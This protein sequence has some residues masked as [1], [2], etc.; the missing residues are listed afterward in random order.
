MQQITL[1]NTLLYREIFR[2]Y[3][4]DEIRKI[5][6]LKEFREKKKMSSYEEL[7]KVIKGHAVRYPVNFLFDED[8]TLKR[9]DKEFYVPNINFT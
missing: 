8:L 1:T 2:C 6:Q 5:D 7:S 9:T 4:D 3:P